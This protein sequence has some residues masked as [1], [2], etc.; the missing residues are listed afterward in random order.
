[1]DKGIKKR[2]LIIK[3]LQTSSNTSDGVRFVDFY[4]VSTYPYLA[5]I[6][7]RTGECMKSF[8]NVTVDTMISDLN[9][10]LSTHA[11]PE[12]IASDVT[13]YEND[14]SESFNSV[15]ETSQSVR[16]Y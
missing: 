13:F 8:N 11:S 9:D 14:A 4:N 10:M 7:P 15:Q 6:D 3:I 1:M 12:S 2:K 16:F 5:I